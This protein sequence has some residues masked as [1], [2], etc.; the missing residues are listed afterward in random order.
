MKMP[1]PL[2]IAGAWALV[3]GGGQ[4]LAWACS[5]APLPP[6]DQILADADVVVVG[7]VLSVSGCGANRHARI[8]VTEAWKGANIGDVLT[9]QTAR[10]SAAC[11][12]E[13]VAGESWLL[14]SS[15]GETANLC[16]G[17][18]P[19]GSGA[20]WLDDLMALPH[21]APAD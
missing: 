2:R 11:G 17:S 5:C 10:D 6:T 1:L 18:T 14:V 9:I 19:T 8:E 12:V 7:D 3:F 21:D 15:D 4:A 16:G 20:S 13:F